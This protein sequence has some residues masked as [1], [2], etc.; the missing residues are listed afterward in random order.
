[1]VALECARV[2]ARCQMRAV[3]HGGTCLQ[4][5]L[6]PLFFASAV[7]PLPR[8][9]ALCAVSH[10]SLSRVRCTVPS[11]LPLPAAAVWLTRCCHS[12]SYQ[13]LCPPRQHPTPSTPAQP[14]RPSYRAPWRARSHTP[15]RDQTR[16][17]LG[18][19]TMHKCNENYSVASTRPATPTATPCRLQRPPP[20]PLTPRSPPRRPPRWTQP[21]Q[22]RPPRLCL[23]PLRLQSRPRVLL[24][25]GPKASVRRC[26]R[27]LHSKARLVF[28]Y[29]NETE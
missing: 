23:A 19:P 22:R 8:F 18:P 14:W 24:H 4:V 28:M 25:H 5:V 7:S 6:A 11:P 2:V 12:P 9:H 29:S 26:H 13:S 3:T 27:T 10:G 17:R 1:M 20:S 21:L 15:P 16:G